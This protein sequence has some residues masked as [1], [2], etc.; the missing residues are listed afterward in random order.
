MT[1]AAN[2]HRRR[3]WSLGLDRF[4]A[5]YLW[6]FFIV[7]FGFLSPDIFLTMNTAHLVASQ[8]AIAGIVAVAL[9]IPM[10]AGEFDLS[11]GANANLTA[12]IAIEAQVQWH[13][14]LPASIAA[15]LVVGLLTGLVNGFVVVVLKVS[16]FIATLAMTSILSAVQVIVTNSQQPPPAINQAWS[17]LTQ[18]VVGGFQVIIVYLLVIAA[19]VWWMMDFTPFGRYLYA[20]GGN[21]TS[22]RLTGIRVDAWRFTALALS[23]LLSGVAGILFASLSTPSLTF[24]TTLLL[25]AFAAVFLGSTQLQP[26]RFNIWGTL[27][28]IYVLAT[29]VEGL[30]LVSGQ[31]WLGDMFNG[32]AL[33]VAVALAVTRGSRDKKSWGA[34]RR[35]WWRRTS[36]PSVSSGTGSEAGTGLV[37]DVEPKVPVAETSEVEAP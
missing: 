36:R 14:S 37:G 28:A 35:G 19:L 18:H 34:G 5:I 8:Q 4:S 2:S 13:W 27:L 7:L 29:G 21:I 10:A 20:I 30:Q 24:G 25:P 33:I 6:A 22:A 31:Q 17:N 1:D 9:L 23:G 32:V 16:S 3:S 11:I 26:G 12:I 15:A